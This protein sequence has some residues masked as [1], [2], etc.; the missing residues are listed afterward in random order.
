[1][2]NCLESRPIVTDKGGH[3][4]RGIMDDEFSLALS[5]SAQWFSGSLLYPL[6]HHGLPDC[7][8]AFAAENF[9]NEDIHKQR[10]NNAICFN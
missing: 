9:E 3:E 5:L 6:L 10:E 2:I 1:M 4:V 8:I 7:I